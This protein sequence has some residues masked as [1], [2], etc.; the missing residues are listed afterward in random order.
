VYG[1]VSRLLTKPRDVAASA[2]RPNFGGSALN[3]VRT[4]YVSPG[5]YRVVLASCSARHDSSAPAEGGSERRTNAPWRPATGLGGTPR[6]CDRL[7][8][9]ASVFSV[10]RESVEGDLGVRNPSAV[11]PATDSSSQRRQPLD[12]LIVNEANAV[13]INKRPVRLVRIEYVRRRP[14]RHVH[15]LRVRAAIATRLSYRANSLKATQPSA[16]ARVLVRIGTDCL[17]LDARNRCAA[18]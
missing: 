12:L 1:R 15:C 13:N 17:R 18:R 5:R 8:H 4:D 14:L 10:C 9:T 11:A 7:P 6:T 16:T 3:S 2:W